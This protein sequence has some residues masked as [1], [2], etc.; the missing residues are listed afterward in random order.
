MSELQSSQTE[1]YV[2]RVTGV[3]ITNEFV[4][5]PIGHEQTDDRIEVGRYQV[6]GP[7]GWSDRA[8]PGYSREHGQ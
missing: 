6:G 4:V 1:S 3:K 7:T 8:L 2:T 5:E